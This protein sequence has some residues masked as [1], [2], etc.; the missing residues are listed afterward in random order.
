M[1]RNMSM[2]MSLVFSESQQIPGAFTQGIN[3][4]MD[5]LTREEPNLFEKR[6]SFEIN[7]VSYDYGAS[8]SY[9]DVQN[10]QNPLKININCTSFSN[11][12]IGSFC[13][14]VVMTSDKYSYIE[15][16]KINKHPFIEETEITT[17]FHSFDMHMWI[18]DLVNEIFADYVIPKMVSHSFW[19]IHVHEVLCKIIPDEISQHILSY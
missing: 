3:D 8:I 4:C 18:A 12:S 7:G 14:D 17:I 10:S 6:G 2:S 19:K 11:P 15:I 16:L 1:I 13:I 5:Y 9:A